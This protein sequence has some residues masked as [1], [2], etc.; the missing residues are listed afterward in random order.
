MKRSNRKLCTTASGH[1]IEGKFKS[2]RVY[3]DFSKTV[4]SSDLRCTDKNVL[5][6]HRDALA[7]L[8]SIQAEAKACYDVLASKGQK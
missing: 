8:P 5:A 4:A 2:H 6:Q 3:T 7:Q 1:V